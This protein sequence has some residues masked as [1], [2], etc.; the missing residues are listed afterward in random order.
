MGMRSASLS[1][2]LLWGSYGSISWR[3]IRWCWGWSRGIFKKVIVGGAM[4][5]AMEYAMFLRDAWCGARK[6]NFWVL[7]NLLLKSSLVVSFPHPL[8]LS[9]RSGADIILWPGFV[10]PL[11]LTLRWLLS[12]HPKYVMLS[13]LWWLFSRT[14]ECYISYVVRA[15]STT[16]IFGT[17]W[18]HPW[19]KLFM[20]GAAE[21]GLDVT[22]SS[23]LIDD[24]LLIFRTGHPF[25]RLP[26]FI[27]FDSWFIE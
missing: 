8:S 2:S 22:V 7:L 23:L 1:S 6:I 18:P 24:C 10:R 20:D 17:C 12:F 11:L 15:H 9:P 13:F 16:V 25:R 14:C 3:W 21:I 26:S 27:G 19:Q 5:M 4:A